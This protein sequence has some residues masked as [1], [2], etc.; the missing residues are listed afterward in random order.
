[1][2]PD[3]SRRDF[4]KSSAAASAAIGAS[5]FGILSAAPAGKTIKVAVIGCGGRGTGALQNCIDA[6]KAI[7]VDVQLVGAADAFQDR[8]DSVVQK[9]GLDPKKA[10]VGWDAYKKLLASTE[11]ELVLTAAPPGFRPVHVEAIINAGKHLFA[12]KPVGVD[13]PGIR[14]IIAAGEKAKEKGLSIVAGTQRRHQNVYLENAARIAKGAIGKILGGVVQW[15]GQIPWIYKR[16]DGES[17]ADYMARNWLNFTELSGDH[18]VEQHVHNLDVACW[19][20]GRPPE[21]ALGF[22]GRHRRVTGNQ[23]DFFSIDYD[24][25]DGVHIHGQCRQIAGCANAVTEFFRGTEGEVIPG[26][27]LTGKDVSVPEFKGHDNPYVQEHIDLINSIFDKKPLN[28]AKQVAESTL[29]AIM[30][31][32][33]AYTGQK[34]RWVDLMEPTAKSPLYD[35]V[36]SPNPEDF[37]KGTVKAPADDVIAHPGKEGDIHLKG[38]AKPQKGKKKRN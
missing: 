28:E 34:V 7:G 26:G 32:I 6:G 20:L 16:K 4:I 19:L 24:F 21:S 22:G 31:R 23:Y 12:E 1:M 15:N 8:V 38:E 33:S 3:L 18:I 37:E 2:K 29:T 5:S 17:D 9:F 11:A 10:F 36:L 13:A 25:G 27:K 35:M 14:R 30:G